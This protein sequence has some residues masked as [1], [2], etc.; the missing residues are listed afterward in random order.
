MVTIFSFDHVTGENREL[1]TRDEHKYNRKKASSV[2]WFDFDCYSCPLL[3][4]I[5]HINKLIHTWSKVMQWSPQ[6]QTCKDKLAKMF[7]GKI[8]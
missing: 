8:H 1:C 7:A 5:K 3:F 4:C 6:R 2:W